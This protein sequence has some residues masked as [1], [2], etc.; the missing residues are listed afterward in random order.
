MNTELVQEVAV[1]TAEVAETAARSAVSFK[2]VGII[3]ACAAGIAALGFGVVTLVKHFKRKKAV[4]EEA[5]DANSE[6]L[7]ESDHEYIKI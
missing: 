4:V 6:D 7:E 2:K 5:E 3:A 1:E